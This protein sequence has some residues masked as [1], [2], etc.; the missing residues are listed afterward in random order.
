MA[1]L[2]C[3]KFIKIFTLQ[4]TSCFDFLPPLETVI[5][6]SEEEYCKSAVTFIIFSFKCLL[7]IFTMYVQHQNP[8]I[9][10]TSGT[11]PGLFC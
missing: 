6:I 1:C 11:I 2:G 5:L 10:T 7:E 9:Y 4:T 8:V 3:S